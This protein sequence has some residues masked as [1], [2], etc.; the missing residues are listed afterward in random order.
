MEEE[1]DIKDLIIALWKKKLIIIIFTA[2]FFVVGFLLYGRTSNGTDSQEKD[3]VQKI[4]NIENKCYETDFMLARGYN[5]ELDGVISTYKIGIDAGVINNLNNFATSQLFLEKMISEMNLNGKIKAEELKEKIT[6]IT[7][8]AGD[9]VTLIVAYGDDEVAS[10]ISNRI[11]AELTD[12]INSLYL[13]NQL[14]II[15]GPRMLSAEE[16][17]ELEDTIS[18]IIAEEQ[19][20]DGN[21]EEKQEVKGPSKKKVI[22]VTAI[23]FVIPCGIIIVM[24]LFNN[25][26]KN[27][28]NIQYVTKKNVL[29]KIFKN[30]KNIDEKIDLIRVGIGNCKNVVITSPEKSSGKTFI[31]NNLVKSYERNGKKVALLDANN[32]TESKLNELN[33]SYDII[34][35]DSENILE[36]A[37]TLEAIKMIKNTI[38]VSYER[39]TNLEC[40][41]KAKN[42][43]ENMGGILIGNVLNGS[44][45]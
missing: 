3:A 14:N 8:S 40:L 2:V 38:L 15:D 12:K 45:K 29:A 25:S 34:I 43:I 13:I 27:E 42:N 5:K 1:I 35:I 4:I 28:E 33:S 21:K 36:S 44:S 30:D 20:K 7:K 17:N 39:K 26:V 41:L 22:L 23:G 6:I 24:E 10:E 37:K 9:V 19:E 31:A 18:N 32:L 11:L 16:V